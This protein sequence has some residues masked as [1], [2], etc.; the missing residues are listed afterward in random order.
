MRI[1]E[2]CEARG[3]PVYA[4][5][6]DYRYD[7]SNPDRTVNVLKAFPKLK[8]VGPHFGG[9]SVWKDALK[10][11]PEYENI[12]VDTSSSLFWMD[13]EFAREI[14]RAYGSKRVM[15]GT[16]TPMWRHKTEL[17][18]M[19]S[20]GLTDEELK[21]IMWRTCAKLLDIHF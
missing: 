14:I 20:L 5:T 15:F 7:R 1:Y 6:G 17:D 13:D 3:L 8:F 19:N 10:T 16:D 12:T 21:D 9:W 18:R 2:M 4:H 11:L